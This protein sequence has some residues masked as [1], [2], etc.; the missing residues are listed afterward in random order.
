MI[1]GIF[2]IKINTSVNI[3][4]STDQMVRYDRGVNLDLGPMQKP[5][6]EAMI[7]GDLDN[8]RAVIGMIGRRNPQRLFQGANLISEPYFLPP[9]VFRK[10]KPV[11]DVPDHE[12]W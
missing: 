8:L 6:M 7:R 10:P 9:L 3:G 2:L 11:Q 4:R 1:L 12:H 5:R